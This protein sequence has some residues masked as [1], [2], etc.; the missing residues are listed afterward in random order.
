MS[1]LISVATTRARTDVRIMSRSHVLSHRTQ[2]F[3]VHALQTPLVVLEPTPFHMYRRNVPQ[4]GAEGT[5]WAT[6]PSRSLQDPKRDLLWCK[7]FKWQNWVLYS[8]MR[9]S[10]L[11]KLQVQIRNDRPR[12]R[13]FISRTKQHMSRFICGI[14]PT[15]VRVMH[16]FTISN[17]S[18]RRFENLA[19]CMV[20]PSPIFHIP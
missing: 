14:K 4:R 17:D 19:L 6:A 2:L 1:V 10:W 8:L 12:V 18:P 15:P 16:Q 20:I 9:M 5:A 11:I 7:M 13:N 3:H